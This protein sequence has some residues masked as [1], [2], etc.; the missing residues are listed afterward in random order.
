MRIRWT[1]PA[2]VD[3]THICDYI[4][5]QN[6]PDVAGRIAREIHGRIGSLAEFPLLGRPGRKPTTRELVFRGLPYIAIYRTRADI[7]EINRI[8]HGAQRWP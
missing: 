1:E 3:L 4:E 6:G 8:L 5:K 7:I 2:A